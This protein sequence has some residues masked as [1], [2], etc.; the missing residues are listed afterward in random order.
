[1]QHGLEALER[2]YRRADGLYRTLCDDSG[3]ILDDYAL[4][5]DQAFVLLA[6]A[7]ATKAG[8]DPQR[9]TAEARQLRGTIEEKFARSGGGF[10]EQELRGS[11]FQSNPHMH[12]LEAALAWCETDG[13]DG[14]WASLAS[15]LVALCLAHFV[16]SGSGMLREFFDESGLP[17]SGLPG[18]IV[19]PG[20]QFEWAWLLA[21]W[22]EMRGDLLAREAARRLFDIGE[23]Y[24]IDIIRGV[25]I[26]VLLADMSPHS[27][28]ARLWPQT[29]RLKA[30][31]TLLRHASDETQKNSLERCALAAAEGVS[32]YL[33]T[34]VPGLWRDKM[35]AD[36][37]FV[38]E[39]SPASSL[40]HIVCAVD[41]LR[42]HMS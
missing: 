38:D 10:V 22:S 36:G 29:E 30:A 33:H 20:H 26:D 21:R 32:H 13:K 28:Q 12:L 15:S 34:S 18:R 5:Y 40:Y 16:D 37:T 39:T 19:E 14:S 8:A 4:L 11:T 25:A 31:L 42:K 35:R 7:T 41:V 1:V 3:G 6:L 27:R 17:L 9:C 23:R 24:G 2:R